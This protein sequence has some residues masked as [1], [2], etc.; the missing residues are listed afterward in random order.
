[1]TMADRSGAGIAGHVGRIVKR[2]AASTGWRRRGWLALFGALAALA[3]PPIHAVVFLPVAFSGLLV[4]MD[5]DAR[6]RAGFAAG[7]WFGLGHFV[8]GTYWLSNSM[9]TDP[10]RYGWMIPFAIGGLSAVLAVFPA[11]AACATTWLRP[12]G[13]ARVLVLAIAWT[14]AEWLRGWVLTGFPW[15]LIGYAWAFSDSMN[16]FAAWFGIWGLSFVTVAASAT[17]ALLVDWRGARRTGE[18]HT[19]R[20]KPAVAAVALAIVAL[21]AVWF[22]GSERLAGAD[23]APV[24]DV[25]LRLV[26][27]NIDPAR[28]GNN[29]LRLANLARH[30]ALTIDTPGFDKVTHVIWPETAIMFLL[31]REYDVRRAVAAV[32]PTDGLL[33]SGAPRA[34]QGGQERI[35]NSMAAIDGEGAILATYDKF[36][37]VPYGEYVPWRSLMPFV[38]KL[39]PGE[40]DFSA[41]PGPR[42]LRLPGLPPVGPLICY[43]VIFPGRVADPS[44]RPDWLLNLTN[45]GWFG[46]STGPYQHLV[47]ARLRAVEEGLPIVRSANTGISAVI[48]AYGRIG[49]RK[50]LGEAGVL[51][52]DLPRPA[53]ALTWY[54]RFGDWTAAGLLL[55]AALAVY[56]M[57]NWR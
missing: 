44:D 10:A 38:S 36:H 26:Q 3:L 48:D 50:G 32:V 33:L 56:L 17:P 28:K 57:R 8:V 14:V 55:M 6:P 23:S 53:A 45:D 54:A 40:T 4:L 11:L 1:M 5:G 22:V 41:G 39:T 15:N 19:V 2:I 9:L 25:R 7:W 47:S 18:M 31:D 35:W 13:P 42:T 27:P 46:R 43:E 24:P 51:D 49:D 29:D 37:L 52:V 30:L 16:Q 34:E 12:Q 21:A 20:R